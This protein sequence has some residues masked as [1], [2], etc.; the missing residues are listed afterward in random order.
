[1]SDRLSIIKDEI[2]K[3]QDSFCEESYINDKYNLLLNFLFILKQA[4]QYEV[5]EELKEEIK[6]FLNTIVS[7]SETFK[8]RFK[9]RFLN[10]NLKKSIANDN[11]INECF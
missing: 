5:I 11:I 7:C 8:P 2:T 9:E 6:N 3:I 10:K 1:M 4:Y